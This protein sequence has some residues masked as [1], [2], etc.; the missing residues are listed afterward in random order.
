MIPMTAILIGACF[1]RAVAGKVMGIQAALSLPFLLSISP[2]VGIVRDRS[3]SFVASFQ[4]LCGL[5]VVAMLLI[6]LLR[7]P[8]TA[9][10]PP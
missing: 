7:I 1:G 5:L 2:L 9:S 4:I 6:A 10:S 8:R 3:G